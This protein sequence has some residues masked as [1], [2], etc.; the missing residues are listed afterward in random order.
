MIQQGV[1]A[2]RTVRRNEALSKIHS[3][4]RGTL[5]GTGLRRRAMAEETIAL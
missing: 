2:A 3:H 1:L 4:T 5:F